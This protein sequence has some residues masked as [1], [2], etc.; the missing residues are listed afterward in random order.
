M[1]SREVSWPVFIRHGKHPVLSFIEDL[2]VWQSFIEESGW[3][4]TPGDELVDSALQ[5]WRLQRGTEGSVRVETPQ[6]MPLAEAERLVRQHL[7]NQG[8]CCISKLSRGDI[9]SL[10]DVLRSTDDF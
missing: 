1:V 10:M 8:V 4:I 6:P 9:A 5:R 2:T 3:M 7:S